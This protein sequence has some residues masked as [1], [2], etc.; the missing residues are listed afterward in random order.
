MYC[1]NARKDFGL[2]F[3]AFSYGKGR[4]ARAREPASTSTIPEAWPA[5]LPSLAS[6]FGRE[7]PHPQH[8]AEVYP[9]DEVT[10]SDTCLFLG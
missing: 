1:K 9:H 8:P 5:P 2:Q 3:F 4:C 10:P 7:S 6:L